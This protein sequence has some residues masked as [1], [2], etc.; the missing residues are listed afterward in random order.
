MAL[1]G[2]G[3]SWMG[4]VGYIGVEEDLDG[5]NEMLKVMDVFDWGWSNTT[6]W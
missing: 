6:I 2:F 3:K 1:M 4:L 5:C